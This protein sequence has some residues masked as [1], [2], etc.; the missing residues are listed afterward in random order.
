MSA[1]LSPRMYTAPFSMTRFSAPSVTIVPLVMSISTSKY[2][3]EVG[4]MFSHSPSSL[5]LSTARRFQ[6]G[7][8]FRNHLLMLDPPLLA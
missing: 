3:G 2:E 6:L 8:N 7:I 4:E 5:P 1:I